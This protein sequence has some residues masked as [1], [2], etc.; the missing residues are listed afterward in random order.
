MILN[1]DQEDPNLLPGRYAPCFPERA[2]YPVG[3]S[4]LLALDRKTGQTRW[5]LDRRT[6]FSS[7]STPCIYEDESGRPLLIVT[8]VAHGITAVDPRT[9]KVCWEFGQPFLDRALSSPIL[10]RGLIIA[11]HGSGTRG[12]RYIAVRPG[13]AQAGAKP[14]LAYQLKDDIPLIPTPLIYDDR[15]FLWTDEGGVSCRRLDTGCS[16]GKSK[17]AGPTTRRPVGESLPVQRSQEWKGRGRGGGRRVRSFGPRAAGRV[18]LCHSGGGRRRDVSA[19]PI[20]PVFAGGNRQS[21]PSAG[22]NA[23]P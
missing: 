8:G 3:K 19:D 2:P 22:A 9:G 4:S 11:G 12:S 7:Y 15:L 10:G 17:W 1:N 6:S 5:Q 16:S 20:P 13:G 21:Q 14:E 23:A 18:K